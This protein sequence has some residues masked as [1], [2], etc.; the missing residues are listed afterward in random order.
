MNYLSFFPN[1]EKDIYELPIQEDWHTQM[2]MQIKMG[3]LAL[4]TPST[5]NQ[6][7]DK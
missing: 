6:T 3:K 4:K 7:M 2:P 1:R 5:T